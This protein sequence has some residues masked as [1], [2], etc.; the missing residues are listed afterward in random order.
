MF[1]DLTTIAAMLQPIMVQHLT[2][3]HIIAVT[4]NA[5]LET[6]RDYI[7]PENIAGFIM[8]QFITLGESGNAE[9]ED[10]TE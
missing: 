10:H 8:E 4:V 1:P 7:G 5:G 2:N 3:Q 6:E 9:S